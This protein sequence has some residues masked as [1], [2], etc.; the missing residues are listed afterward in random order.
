[1]AAPKIACCIV[2]MNR[3]KELKPCLDSCFAQT[4]PFEKVFVYDNNSTDGVTQDFLKETGKTRKDFGYVLADKNL[5]CSWGWA[6]LMRE[7]A[8][9]FDAFFIIDD[10]VVLDKDAI[11]ELVESAP[12]KKG[13]YGFLGSLVLDFDTKEVA[14]LNFPWLKIAPEAGA[15]AFQKG[16]LPVKTSSFVGMLVSRTAIEKEGLPVKEFFIYADDY[17]YS[18]RVSKHFPC[19]LVASSVV[20]HKGKS[21]DFKDTPLPG[22][23]KHYYA[24]RNLMY[25]Y[26]RHRNLALY[27]GDRA[28]VLARAIRKHGLRSWPYISTVVRGLWSGLFFHPKVER[29]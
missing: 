17:E 27:F 28:I 21:I 10:D 5:G 22:L 8:R 20:L 9:E 7:H 25:T 24:T 4:F 1:M 2:T 13:D 19:Y 14:P 3:L 18:L 6:L 23:W 16:V 15:E 11:K 12:F 29:I 26:R